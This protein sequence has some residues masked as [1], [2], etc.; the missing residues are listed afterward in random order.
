MKQKNKIGELRVKSPTQEAWV[1]V[2]ERIKKS[3]RSIPQEILIM[4]ISARKPMPLGMGGIAI[5]LWLI[6]YLSNV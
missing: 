4:I 3:R 2:M 6:N 1:Y 5:L